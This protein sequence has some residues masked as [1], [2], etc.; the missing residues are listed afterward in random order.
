[1]CFEEAAPFRLGQFQGL[2]KKGLDY[3]PPSA[4]HRR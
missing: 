1:M 3:L 4:V 2:V